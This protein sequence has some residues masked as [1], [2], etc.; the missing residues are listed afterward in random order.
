MK[1]INTIAFSALLGI[2]TL[3]T[4]NG[5]FALLPDECITHIPNTSIQYERH[6]VVVSSNDNVKKLP[7]QVDAQGY[8]L[9]INRVRL[10]SD[11]IVEFT[12]VRL[13]A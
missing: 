9:T 7:E 1:K 11:I 13:G 12:I 8:Y 2:A 10:P 6:G 5:S 4:A 3:F